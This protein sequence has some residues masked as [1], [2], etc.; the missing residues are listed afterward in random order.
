M[1][2]YSSAGMIG[3]TWG[4]PRFW[5]DPAIVAY[6]PIA[7]TCLLEGANISQMVRMWTQRTAAG[8]SLLAWVCVGSALLLWANW[9]RI[10]TPEQRIA[11]FTIKIGIALNFGVILSVAYFRYAVGRG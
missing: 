1:G 9:Y 6:S 11:R 8:Q 2:F 10:V 3:P 7:T 5:N 4:R